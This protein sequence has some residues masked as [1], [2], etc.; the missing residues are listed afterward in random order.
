LEYCVLFG[1]MV[2]DAKGG[3]A[4]VAS[5]RQTLNCLRMQLGITPASQAK[6]PMPKKAPKNKW[7]EIG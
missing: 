7:A 6:V 3:K 1:R 4:L 2:E 5:E